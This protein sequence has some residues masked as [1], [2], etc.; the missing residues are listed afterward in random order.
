V[1]LEI[2]DRSSTAYPDESLSEESDRHQEPESPARIAC[3]K[4]WLPRCSENPS[5]GRDMSRFGRKLPGH[6]AAVADPCTDDR[7]LNVGDKTDW[8]FTVN[9]HMP[10]LGKLRIVGSIEREALT[11]PYVVFVTN[12]M[13]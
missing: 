1:C 3:I 10:G 8:C 5:V 6:E 13:D 11:G 7:S 2:V 9:V 12:Q 4:R